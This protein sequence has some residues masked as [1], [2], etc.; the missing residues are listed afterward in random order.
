MPE[1]EYRKLLSLEDKLTIRLVTKKGKVVFFVVQYYALIKG[2]WKTIMRAD[3]CHGTGHIHRY[4]LQSKEFKLS[5]NKENSKAFNDAREHI[6]K[7]FI[8]IKENFL[9]T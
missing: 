4:H 1:K 5:L 6:M 2:K 7:D 9:N 8:K 3:N